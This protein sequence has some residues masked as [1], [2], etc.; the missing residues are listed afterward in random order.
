MG[1]MDEREWFREEFAGTDPDRLWTAL[2]RVLSTMDLKQADDGTRV[3]LFSTGT[4]STSWGQHL[5]AEVTGGAGGA[6]LTVRGRPRASFL[7]SG[8]GEDLHM[9]S[10]RGQLVGDVRSALA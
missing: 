5:R 7:S 4:T 10:V 8:W 9:R 6:V 2:R 1:V 3:A